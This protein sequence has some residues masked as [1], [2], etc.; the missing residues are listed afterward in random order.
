MNEEQNDVVADFWLDT[1]TGALCDEARAHIAVE[2]RAHYA[3]LVEAHIAEG[4]TLDDARLKALEDLGDA[5]VAARRFRKQHLTK[6]EEKLIFSLLGPVKISTLIYD[7]FQSFFG[8]VSVMLLDLGLK[9]AIELGLTFL[10]TVVAFPAAIRVFVKPV[11][12]GTRLALTLLSHMAIRIGVGIFFIIFFSKYTKLPPDRYLVSMVVFG[13]SLIVSACVHV[14][15][16]Y[17]LWRKFR[18]EQKWRSSGLE[19]S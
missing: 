18:H 17:R 12:S 9:R 16:D 8:L 11:H 3:D 1:A 2:I 7:P 10:I 14:G 5:E 15:L 19:A 6:K 13:W 4:M